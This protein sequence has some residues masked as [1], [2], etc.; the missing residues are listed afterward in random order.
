MALAFRSA[1]YSTINPA[2]LSTVT[3]QSLRSMSFKTSSR[4][5]HLSWT[6]KEGRLLRIDEH[7]DDDFVE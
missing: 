5:S 7:R 6:V 1:A 4:I 3:R 2:K